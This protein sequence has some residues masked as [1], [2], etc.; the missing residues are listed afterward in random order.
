MFHAIITLISVLA[1]VHGFGLQNAAAQNNIRPYSYETKNI[2]PFVPKNLRYGTALAL[3]TRKKHNLCAM[4]LPDQPDPL[5]TN[6]LLNRL[7]TKVDVLISDV[8]LLKSDVGE[9][10]SDVGYLTESAMT[11]QI[12]QY[13]GFDFTERVLVATLSDLIPFATLMGMTPYPKQQTLLRK[14]E[15]H[16]LQNLVPFMDSLKKYLRCP[17]DVRFTANGRVVPDII[18][19]LGKAMNSDYIPKS[20]KRLANVVMRMFQQVDELSIDGVNIFKKGSDY[21]SWEHAKERFLPFFRSILP[22]KVK[23]AIAASD[24]LNNRG[25]SSVLSDPS[26]PGLMIF[27]WSSMRGNGETEWFQTVVEFDCR[28]RITKN[29]LA[30]NREQYVVEAAEIKRSAEESS[31]NGQL[32]LRL[33]LLENTLKVA[34]GA[35]NIML[36]GYKFFRR[37]TVK[38]Q[39]RQTLIQSNGMGSPIQ[40]VKM[41]VRRGEAVVLDDTQV[42][43]D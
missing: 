8:S 23:S 40:L 12:E 24:A 35:Y 10:K 2:C 13:F 15:Q 9:V 14:L 39:F 25:I 30:S 11:P 41:R 38:A 21:S 42:M 33:R 32:V 16:T 26:G 34:L 36:K 29:V 19:V 20:R 4:S 22:N 7:I 31:G 28:G 17:E 1:C 27:L 37:G 43:M 3:C 5:D 6:L 18:P